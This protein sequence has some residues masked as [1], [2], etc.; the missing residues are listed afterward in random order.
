MEG[1]NTVLLDEGSE[2]RVVG[3][4]VGHLVVQPSSIIFSHGSFWVVLQTV[5]NV[6]ANTT[7]ILLSAARKNQAKEF[8]AVV[9]AAA[10]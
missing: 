7:I 10:L 2:D 4:R 5:V 9:K 1:W 3:R 6:D 8:E